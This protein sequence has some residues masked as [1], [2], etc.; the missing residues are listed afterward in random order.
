M[1]SVYVSDIC[2]K[3]Q[4]TRTKTLARLRVVGLDMTPISI[5]FWIENTNI[6]KHQ[7]QKIQESANV[8]LLVE[9]SSLRTSFQKGIVEKLKICCMYDFYQPSTWTTQT[10]GLKVVIISNMLWFCSCNSLFRRWRVF[11]FCC[12]LHGAW[13]GF[14]RRLGE[15]LGVGTCRSPGVV[16]ESILN[17]LQW[18]SVQEVTISEERDEHICPNG[19]NASW[20]VLNSCVAGVIVIAHF[21]SH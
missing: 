12:T 10:K 16:T 2:D 18:F 8:W 6:I 17:L 14:G 4:R 19:A 11:F 9:V 15:S 5:H 3:P 1:L 21:K 20:N 7:H 13:F